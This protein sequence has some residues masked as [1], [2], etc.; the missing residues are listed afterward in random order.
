MNFK[1]NLEHFQVEY[2]HQ[3]TFSDF[4][5]FVTLSLIAANF[6]HLL[7]T[8]ANSLDTDQDTLIAFLKEF[9]ENT[10]LKKV[11]IQQQ[12][13]EKLPSMLRVKKIK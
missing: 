13:H 7:I 1:V 5:A 2:L 9:F 8:F 4:V 11:S 3:K 6:C 10:I 12:K